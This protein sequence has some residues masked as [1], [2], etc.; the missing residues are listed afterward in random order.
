MKSK[1]LIKSNTPS[2]VILVLIAMIACRLD[3]QENRNARELDYQSEIEIVSKIGD[4]DSKLPS[5][6]YFSFFQENILNQ[7]IVNPFYDHVLKYHDRINFQTLK[8]QKH[9]ELSTD[10]KKSLLFYYSHI[11]FD[12]EYHEIIS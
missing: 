11:H 12:T 10:T 1:S 3:I 2:L 5:F 4:V 7:L 8:N 6:C 9:I